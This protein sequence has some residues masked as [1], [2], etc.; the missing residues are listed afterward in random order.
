MRN[1]LSKLIKIAVMMVV[2]FTTEVIKSQTVPEGFELEQVSENWIAPAGITYADNG[3]QYVWELNGFVWV[4]EN[5]IKDSEPFIDIAE[6][7]AF[8]GD[9]GLVGFALDPDF[10]SNGYVYLLYALD[11]HYL[12]QFGSSNYDPEHTDSWTNQIGRVTRFQLDTGDY[13]TVI[14]GSR[15]VLLGQTAENG[16]AI[17][18]PTHG[19]GSL[20]FGADG[21]LIISA[22]EGTTWVDH[23][24]G[25][26]PVP[27]FGYETAALAQGML[28]D[29]EDIGSFRAQLINGPNGKL[30]R[31]NPETGAGYASNPF[32]VEGEPFADQSKVWALGLRNPFRFSLKPNTG[33]ND[34]ELG[35]PGTF[36]IG[37]VGLT[38][39][40]ELNICNEPGQNFGWPRY[41][42]MN[43]QPG[44]DPKPTEN[45]LLPNALYNGTTCDIEH[46]RFR[47]LIKQPNESHSYFFS[48]PCDQWE[49]IEGVHTFV[50]ERPAVAF[51][52]NANS[53]SIQTFV[54]GYDPSGNALGLSLEQAGIGGEEF[55]GI[56]S[57]GGA[58]YNSISYPEEY[59]GAYF[60]ADL[61]GWVNAFWFDENDV[62]TKVE[63]FL[64]DLEG[65]VHLSVNPFDGCLYFPSVYSGR[66]YRICYA[67][68]LKP[69]AEIESDVYYG[70]SP[71]TVQFD[72]S[73]SFDPD[74]DPITHAWDFG[75]TGSSD[76]ISP[77]HTFIAAGNEPQMFEV[78][79]SVTDTANNVGE[80][81]VII[82][83]NNTPPVVDITSFEDGDLYSLQQPTSLDLQ[84]EVSDL[85]HEPQD[86]TYTWQTFFHHNTHYHPQPEDHNV[87]T[88]TLIQPAPCED[89]VTYYYRIRLEVR[90]A[91]GLMGFDE[92]NIY[93]DCNDTIPL[94][95]V[96]GYALFPNPGTDYLTLKSD[97]GLDPLNIKIFNSIGQSIRNEVVLPEGRNNL[98]IEIFQLK[99]GMY[100]LKV[101]EG[102][103]S[104]SIR[105]VKL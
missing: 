42:G 70:P 72:G 49:D 103:E 94:P 90:D 92:N 40:E 69:I 81:T 54:P 65:I 57:V 88:Q 30:L 59:F 76:E 53:S 39:W 55:T 7:V 29:Y 78:K 13:R 91:A 100:I 11:S 102:G 27:E 58:F 12:T 83:L 18:S 87:S 66:I 33:S 2:V 38:K 75:D 77:E 95:P 64:E 25:G 82:S 8:Y 16:I 45:I 61:S 35:D 10:M 47:D 20:N 80:K 36:Y 19:M 62:L 93:P 84:A 14:D 17:P 56:S 96:E 1:P 101:E 85:E 48:N 41:E 31:I 51:M 67:E 21:S 5:G 104:E 98:P 60:H 22:G 63:P 71:L 86:L 105:F 6:E 32:Y 50:H 44:Y 23:Y 4:V 43:L 3:F 46:L 89:N 68:N 52:N 15:T 74:S 34:P 26:L 24:T 28:E 99:P 97:F 9:L 37:D 73:G 79:L